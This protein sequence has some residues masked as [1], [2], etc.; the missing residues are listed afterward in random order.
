M[1]GPSLSHKSPKEAFYNDDDD[2]DNDE[3][4]LH[5]GLT[6][7]RCEALITAET[8]P[9]GSHHCKPPLCREQDLNL[10]RT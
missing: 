9:G 1:S 10:Q 5:C 8:I 7:E 6:G 2:N 4:F 3:L